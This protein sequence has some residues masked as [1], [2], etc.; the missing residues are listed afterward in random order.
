MNNFLRKAFVRPLA[1]VNS[2]YSLPPNKSIHTTTA[3]SFNLSAKLDAE[4][5]KAKKRI[6]PAVL[7]LR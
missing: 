5:T 1:Y 2:C 7:A 6:D 3:I 4:P